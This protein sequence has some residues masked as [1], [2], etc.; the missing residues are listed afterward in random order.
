MS[1]QNKSYAIIQVI[2]TVV[3]LSQSN[4]SNYV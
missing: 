4:R 3:N 2:G 1:V